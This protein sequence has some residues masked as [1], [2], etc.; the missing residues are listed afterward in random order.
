MSRVKKHAVKEEPLSPIAPSFAE[1]REHLKA[2]EAIAAKCGAWKPAQ[3]VLVPVRAVPTIFPSLDIV[4]R[5]GGWPIERFSLIHGPSNEG[6]ALAVNTPILTPKG[7]IPVGDIAIGGEVI[8]G[9]G[10]RT[11]VT[12]VFPQGIVPLFRVGFSDH[13]SVLCCENHLWFTCTNQERQSAMY[14]R[15]PR[16]ARKRIPTGRKDGGSV[17]TLGAIME[18]FVP[19]THALPINGPVDFDE[20]GELPIDPY[21]L[22]L[23]LGDG[24][25]CQFTPRFTKPESDLLAIIECLLPKGDRLNV[26]DAARGV[27]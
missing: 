4:T 6:K 20:I 5:V 24:S 22:G 10:E 25:L 11:V 9:S 19:G 26:L 1:N 27:I 13:S 15:G 7:W 2:M 3:E 21:L 14:M 16:P 8:S 18:G 12:G 23:L 17:K